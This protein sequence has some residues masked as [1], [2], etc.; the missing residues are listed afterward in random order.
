[1]N[2]PGTADLYE[3]LDGGWRILITSD[4]QAPEPGS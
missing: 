4:A 3:H 2:G 1:M